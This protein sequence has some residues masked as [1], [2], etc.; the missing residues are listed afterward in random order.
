M[1]IIAEG[2]KERQKLRTTG[3]VIWF[4]SFSCLG[5]EFNVRSGGAVAVQCQLLLLLGGIY[6][7]ENNISSFKIEY[8]SYANFELYYH[9]ESMQ[10]FKNCLN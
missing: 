7:A 10:I 1:V 4:P 6:I 5:L 8:T 2:N 9:C 3:V